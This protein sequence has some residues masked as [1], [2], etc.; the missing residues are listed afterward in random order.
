VIVLSQGRVLAEFEVALPRPRTWEALNED[1]AFKALT[2][3]AL[4]L[5]RSA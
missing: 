4:Q 3:R 2:G 1:A 5:V